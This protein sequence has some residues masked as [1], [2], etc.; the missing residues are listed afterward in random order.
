MANWASQLGSDHGVPSFCTPR[1]W[2]GMGCRPFLL[3]NARVRGPG[4]HWGLLPFEHRHY[5][6]LL[7]GTP[8][9]GKLRPG[10]G[11][12]C[13]LPKCGPC[14]PLYLHLPIK[15]SEASMIG[16]RKHIAKLGG[17]GLGRSWQA[18]LTWVCK[19][20]AALA[21]TASTSLAVTQPQRER[22]LPGPARLSQRCSQ[23]RA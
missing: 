2:P 22:H 7:H 23:Q 10:L 21:P 15:A 13:F 9:P 16:C 14:N 12:T 6:G 8:L 3:C 11:Q 19:A 5:A 17:V 20:P 18:A 4:P 1:P